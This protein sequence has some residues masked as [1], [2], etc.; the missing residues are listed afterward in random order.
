MFTKI[1]TSSMENPM[2]DSLGF[3]ASSTALVE[4]RA[5]CFAQLERIFSL[6]TPLLPSRRMRS[7]ETV[8]EQ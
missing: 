5:L 2:D 1:D 3:P 8:W 4:E 6:P 7:L